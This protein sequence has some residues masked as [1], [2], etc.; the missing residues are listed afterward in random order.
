MEMEC[1]DFYHDVKI[2]ILIQIKIVILNSNY[3]NGIWSF[4][5][6]CENS[7]P[8]KKIMKKI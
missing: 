8:R 1:V 4:L 7:D 6:K 3:G 2:Q 5:S